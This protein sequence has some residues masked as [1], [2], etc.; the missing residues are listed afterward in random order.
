M[1]TPVRL[2]P[3]CCTWLMYLL[4]L[5]WMKHAVL[6]RFSLGLFCVFIWSAF[7]SPSPS[8]CSELCPLLDEFVDPFVPR[9]RACGSDHRVVFPVD[10]SWLCVYD[11]ALALWRCFFLF[12]VAKLIGASPCAAPCFLFLLFCCASVAR[13]CRRRGVFVWCW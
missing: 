10:A 13:C 8:V 12:W 6:W 11:L 5:L 1:V 4:H 3:M 2:G 9:Q 7:C